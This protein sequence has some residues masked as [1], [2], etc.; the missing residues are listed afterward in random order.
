MFH[1]SD[2]HIDWLNLVCGVDL[3]RIPC[4]SENISIFTIKSLCPRLVIGQGWCTVEL[5]GSF[6]LPISRVALALLS[7][8]TS[9][10]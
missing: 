6:L 4:V 9:L 5:N 1:L 8:L 3:L 7:K 10:H 2:T